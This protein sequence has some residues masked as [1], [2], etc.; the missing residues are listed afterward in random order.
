[1]SVS[2]LFFW[3]RSVLTVSSRLKSISKTN[4]ILFHCTPQAYCTQKM[5]EIDRGHDFCDFLSFLL[6]F[7][8][9][10]IFGYFTDS[11]TGKTLTH[12]LLGCIYYS[13]LSIKTSRDEDCIICETFVRQVYIRQKKNTLSDTPSTGPFITYDKNVAALNLQVAAKQE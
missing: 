5:R 6:T 8:I 1:M 9:K 2:F 12:S 4:L 10:C 7:T 3:S 13:R 11:A